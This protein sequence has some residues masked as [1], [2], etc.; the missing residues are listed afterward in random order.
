MSNELKNM[1]DELAKRITRLEY[2]DG[3]LCRLLDSRND[4]EAHFILDNDIDDR[5]WVRIEDV[6]ESAHKALERGEPLE[7]LHFEKQLLPA[8]P[9]RR[10]P[11]AY[12]FVQGL[13]STFARTGRWHDV[14]E[15]FRGDFNVPDVP[16]L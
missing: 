15:H 11:G 14:V 13:L 4:P 12:S 16:A 10:K 8:I 3:L 6:M 9:W 7:A 2:R 5:E 1:I